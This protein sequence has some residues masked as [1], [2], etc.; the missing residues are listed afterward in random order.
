[1]TPI[2]EVHGG[3][4][5][6]GGTSCCG[7][8]RVEEEGVAEC[9]ELTRIPNPISLCSWEEEVEKIRSQVKSGERCFKI[10]FLFLTIIP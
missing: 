8:E 6:V 7:Q 2:G 5:S 10:C 9:D 3:L 4:S 1:M